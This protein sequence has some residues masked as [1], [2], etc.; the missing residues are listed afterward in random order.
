M[1]E[2]VANSICLLANAAKASNCCKCFSCN[3]NR[4]TKQA[5]ETKPSHLDEGMDL[6]SRKTTSFPTMQ[7]MQEIRMLNASKVS[8]LFTEEYLDF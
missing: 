7:I 8:K 4:T 2:L 6:E 3:S 5:M 1:L